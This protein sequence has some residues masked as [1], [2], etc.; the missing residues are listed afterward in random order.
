MDNTPPLT[1]VP[2]DGGSTTNVR[3]LKY[4]LIFLLSALPREIYLYF[5]LTLPLLY[6]S[7]VDEIFQEVERNK[8][9]I[10]HKMAN[11]VPPWQ[12][13][14]AAD[15]PGI[16]RL[17][18]SWGYFIDSSVKE[19]ETLNIVSVLLSAAILT[20]L[21]IDGVVTDPYTRYFALLAL[22]CSLMS[23]LYGCLYVIRFNAMRR[24]RKILK[25]AEV[26]QFKPKKARS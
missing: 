9:A 18:N 21:Q 8:S 12:Q 3:T 16:T 6:V 23:L 17:V 20:T 26:T 4:I 7:R 1:D 25:W 22:V 5:L 10:E 15:S 19:W 11:D 24:T 13:T 14:L 2:P